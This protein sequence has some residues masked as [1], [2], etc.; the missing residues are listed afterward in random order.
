MTTHNT[1]R[2]PLGVSFHTL[3]PAQ[4]PET[5]EL[6]DGSSVQTVELWEPTFSKSKDHVLLMRNL[7]DTS[8][9]EVRTIHAD[10][11]GSIDISALD[12]PIRSAGIQAFG[13]ALN[14]AT[15]MGAQTVIVHPSSEPITNEAR[16]RRMAKAKSSIMTISD[17]ANNVGCRIALELLPRTCLGHSVEELLSLLDAVDPGI[18]GV[19]LDTNHLMDDF[20][21]LPVVVRNLGPRLLTLHCSDY[22]GVDEKH[23]P[24][25]RGVINWQDFLRAL[26]DVDFSGSFNYEATLDGQTPAERLTFLQDSYTQLLSSIH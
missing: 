20:T 12:Q 8:G 6:L 11:G 18:A 17:M 23:W 22:D 13:T 3:D 16:T 19:C 21:S 1:I 2:F 14:L 24:P 15:R 7:F 5:A 26:R 10:F 25:G 9:V 4:Q